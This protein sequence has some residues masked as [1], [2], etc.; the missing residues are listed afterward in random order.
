VSKKLRVRQV[1]SSIG[2]PL[3]QKRT[4]WALGLRKIGSMNDLPDNAQIRGM[5]RSVRH[6]VHAEPLEGDP[7]A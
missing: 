4:L 5:V 2:R 1:R 6:L 3:R 7:D